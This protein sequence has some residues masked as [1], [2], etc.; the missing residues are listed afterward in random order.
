MNGPS[1]TGINVVSKK[2]LK[3]SL[4][5]WSHCDNYV[6]ACQTHIKCASLGRFFSAGESIGRQD[7]LRLIECHKTPNTD[8]LWSD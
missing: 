6:F 4:I 7:T 5:N 1:S 3:R 2:R 8:V